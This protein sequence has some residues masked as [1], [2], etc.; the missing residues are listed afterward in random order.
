MTLFC[1]RLRA[2]TLI[3]IDSRGLQTL[4]HLL[5]QLHNI[6][7]GIIGFP[8]IGDVVSCAYSTKYS[9][10][11]ALPALP[12]GVP[13]FTVTG[14]AVMVIN[15]F[16]LSSWFSTTSR[17]CFLEDRLLHLSQAKTQCLPSLFSTRTKMEDTSNLAYIAK[18]IDLQ[19]IPGKD[20]IELA[21]VK[22]WKCIVKKG[23]F[24][25]GDFAVYLA[26]G[27]VPDFEDPNFAFLKQKY[28]RIKTVKMGGVVSQ[29]FLCPV[30]FLT[31]RGYSAVADLTEG[32]DVA[33][34]MGVTK[35]VA[36]EEAA[37]YMGRPGNSVGR[38]SF[39]PC[40]PKTDAMRLQHDPD[41]YM[42]ALLGRDVT[43]TR[44]EDGCSCT[45]IFNNGVYQLCGRN[46]VWSD[47]D[48]A[49][50]AAHY[51]HIQ[52]ELS[53]VDKLTA[54]GR[55]IAIQGEICGPKINGNRMKLTAKSFSVF[56]AYDIDRQEYLGYDALCLVCQEL[57][58]STVPLL[59]RG[60]ASEL[61]LTLDGFLKLAEAVEYGKGVP[62]EGIVVK[63]DAISFDQPRVHFKTISN[64]YLLKNDL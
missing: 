26:I 14:L 52:D 49:G 39:P 58:L 55:N 11:P 17:A 31:A 18:V 56:D 62:G 10:C 28:D 50:S 22:G 13:V 5:I 43:I 19:P 44:K 20:K 46:F 57:G 53:L 2:L 61:D 51:F 1:K 35:F 25:V 60:P 6:L 30:S 59:Y 64:K 21:V 48:R 4:F 37:Q 41:H 32:S 45:F 24:G 23:D 9:C 8:Y 16:V 36:P 63:A 7:V 27:S 54:L 29:G 33:S 42:N 34:I 38:V 15:L 40:V 47:E 3:V 12:S